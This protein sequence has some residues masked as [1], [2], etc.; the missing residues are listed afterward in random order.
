MSSVVLDTGVIAESVNL[1]GEFNKQ[2]TIVL[3]AINSDSITAILNPVT[4][5]ELRY[6][7]WRIYDELA[8]K[9]P[10]KVSRDFCEYIYYHPNIRILETSLE[11][12][13]EAGTIKHRYSLTLSD[14][15]VLAASKLNR[16]KA[17]FRH[18]E[19]EIQAAFKDLSKEFDLVFLQDY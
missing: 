4:I 1:E 9:N 13:L 7:L 15:F 18:K 16:C 5:A 19:H 6:V 17:V 10:E 11:M 14:C 12:L 2:A 8:V 3:D